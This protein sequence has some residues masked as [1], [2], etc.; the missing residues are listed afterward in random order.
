MWENEEPLKVL[1]NSLKNKEVNAPIMNFLKKW[2]V[3][4]LNMHKWVRTY[5][6]NL[7]ESDQHLFIGPLI[8]L[9]NLSAKHIK[10]VNS[11]FRIKIK[12]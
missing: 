11:I 2:M 4:K 10:K 6:K 1:T 9:E 5:L 3:D 12:E 7:P 8:V